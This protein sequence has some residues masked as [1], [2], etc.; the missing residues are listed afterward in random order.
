MLPSYSR[1]G[2]EVC[3]AVF[4][5]AVATSAFS[6][7]DFVRVGGKRAADEPV[8]CPTWH[9][10]ECPSGQCV[11][12]KYL[13]DG[14]K[15]CADGYDEDSNMC[16]AATR[17][18][19]EETA[20]FL[21]AVITA[22]SP[23]FFVKVFGP[24]ARNNFSEMGGVDRVAVAIS[25]MHYYSIMVVGLCSETPRADDFAKSVGMNE[26]ELMRMVEVLEG[27][28]NGSGD[29]LTSDEANSFRFLVQK[30]QETGFF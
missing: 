21:N 27:V 18:P 16:T 26:E 13:C 30:L 2:W 10:F 1:L 9:P 17:P 12:I 3:A 11:P 6:I 19:V 4:L 8:K 25:R 22:H 20:A 5:L 15:D 28:M 14:S 23:D 24:K 7:R 29:G